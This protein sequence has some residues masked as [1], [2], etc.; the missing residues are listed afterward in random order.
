MDNAITISY[1]LV[2]P[3][4]P[5]TSSFNIKQLPLRVVNPSFELFISES[6][7]TCK[8]D[9][10][11]F[12][13]RFSSPV[14]KLSIVYRINVDYETLETKRWTY[15]VVQPE[16]PWGSWLGSAYCYFTHYGLESSPRTQ[17]FPLCHIL[18]NEGSYH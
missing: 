2:I 6:T 12:F 17:N 9:N 8:G 10:T 15:D 14:W 7:W 5:L 13:S 16:F 3:R 1:T 18:E 11:T 4:Q